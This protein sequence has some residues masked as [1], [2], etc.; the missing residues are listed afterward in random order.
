VGNFNQ[1]EGPSTVLLYFIFSLFFY[2]S[3]RDIS[4]RE[5]LRCL[6]RIQH[7]SHEELLAKRRKFKPQ[8]HLSVIGRNTYYLISS[9][10]LRSIFKYYFGFALTGKRM[11][12]YNGAWWKEK[13]IKPGVGVQFIHP[14]NPSAR[15]VY[16]RVDKIFLHPSH[17]KGKE[18]EILLYGELGRRTYHFFI[19]TSFLVY[20]LIIPKMMVLL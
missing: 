7:G 8:R 18:D 15:P 5:N 1:L 19:F 12:S 16:L 4:L 17:G 14:H 2:L 13:K 20:F 11:R 10:H 9:P 6:L 3:T